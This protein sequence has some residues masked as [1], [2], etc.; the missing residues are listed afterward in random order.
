MR[1]DAG[2]DYNLK[3]LRGK[4][5]TVVSGYVWQDYITN[6]Y[7]EIAFIPAN[8]VADGL[9]MV[10]FG[11]ADAMIGDMATATYYLQREGITNLQVAGETGYFTYSCFG[12]RKDWPILHSILEKAVAAIPQE[13][14]QA[15]L[16][17]WIKLEQKTLLDSKYFWVGLTVIVLTIFLLF[18]G[19]FA[20]N[21]SLRRL[22]GAKTAE[23]SRELR[24]RIKTE[25]LL[26][27][28]EEKF[29][30]ISANAQDGIIMIDPEGKISFWNRAAQEMFGYTSQE[31]LGRELHLLLAPAS[32][33]QAYLKA[34]EHFTRTGRGKALGN[35]LELT[36]LRKDG[37]EFPVELSVAAMNLRGGWHAVGVVRDVSDRKKDEYEK[38]KLEEQLRHSQKMQAI[39]T[40]AGGLA[41]DFNN[42]LTAVIG[43]GE[44]ALRNKEDSQSYAENLDKILIA[45]ERARGLVSKLLTFSR[46]AEVDIKPLDLDQRI[47][48]ALEILH[49]TLPKMIKMETSF[50]GPGKIINADAG[51]IEQIIL[52]LGINAADAMPQGGV[53][54]FETDVVDF[55]QE[56]QFKPPDL[57]P[58]PH[59][60]LRVIDSGSGMDRETMEHIF[61]PFFTTKGIGKGTGLGLSIV[62]GILKAH[63]GHITCYSHPGQGTCFTLYFPLLQQAESR[64]LE[65]PDPSKEAFQGH[66]GIMVVDDEE[67]IRDMIRQLLSENGYTPLF[68]S[69]GEEALELYRERGGEIDLV[70]LDI[71]MPGM[72][73]HACM[74]KLLE[75]NPGIKVVVASGYSHQ[76]SIRNILAE[77]AKEFIAKPY[78]GKQ[79]LQAIRH[80]LDQ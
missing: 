24:E 39:G 58:S 66:E 5:I 16:D 20:W 59:A 14:N 64:P 11:K 46:K 27:E 68:A 1:K 53:L 34:F 52:N 30:G 76:E 74:K 10:S 19:V 9:K 33:H 42:I 31:A 4:R 65:K 47:R 48:M 6:D 23:L 51:Q 36:A 55:S 15:I 13:E 43:Y 72:G 63:G 77:G 22:V 45:A 61:E 17:Q 49:G 78:R 40:L 7:P 32:Y 62:F 28:S 8:S 71:G 80:S 70:L 25:N 2:S 26:R 12:V 69:S 50:S 37:T 41:H 54:R 60:V 44:L 29:R 75:I 56:K 67:A 73:G 38:K 57:A 21:A 79:L 18:L 3:K 35:T